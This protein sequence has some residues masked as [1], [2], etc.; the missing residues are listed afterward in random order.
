M[1]AALARSLPNRVTRVE[2]AI[3]QVEPATRNLQKRR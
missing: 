3:G 2:V 1:P